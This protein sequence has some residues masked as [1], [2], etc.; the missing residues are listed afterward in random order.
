MLFSLRFFELVFHFSISLVHNICYN[1]TH[2]T[3]FKCLHSSTG[4]DVDH[5]CLFYFKRV[6]LFLQNLVDEQL[7]DQSLDLLLSQLRQPAEERLADVFHL[8]RLR[9]IGN[10]LFFSLQKFHDLQHSHVHSLF[11][12]CV[13]QVNYTARML[14]K[15]Y[16]NDT[17]TLFTVVALLIAILRPE[18]FAKVAK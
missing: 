14:S 4:Y 16:L 5:D 2:C 9:L 13:Y 15:V 17:Q 1:N 8:R 10:A 12:S 3:I 7:H 18:I 11:L 6:K